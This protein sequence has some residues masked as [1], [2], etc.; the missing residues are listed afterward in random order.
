MT[1]DLTD[2]NALKAALQAPP[3]ADGDARARAM[4]LAMENFDR[5]QGSPAAPRSSE[6]RQVP[7][8]FLNGV[9]SMLNFLTSRPA[10]AGT[11]S[12]AALV[13]G[14]AVILPVAQKYKAPVM[15]P[16]TAPEAP[17]PVSKSAEA[18][19]APA[20]DMARAAPP[21]IPAKPAPPL[22]D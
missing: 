13:I 14:V 10:L 19:E 7:A 9:R 16:V 17:S 6:D 5:L 11:T 22:L 8:G 2:L 20:P 4:A 1:D 18:A 3:A 15:P 21:A 12:I